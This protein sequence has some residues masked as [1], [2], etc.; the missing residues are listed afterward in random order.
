MLFTHS[1]SM[2]NPD[3]P[4]PKLL[5]SIERGSKKRKTRFGCS[6]MEFASALCV[7]CNLPFPAHVVMVTV[8]K[9]S[10]PPACFSTV[11]VP[12]GVHKYL[13]SK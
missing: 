5:M 13:N 2:R 3:Y 12:M 4:L 7:F 6:G 11:K 9:V 8:V 10:P 1:T